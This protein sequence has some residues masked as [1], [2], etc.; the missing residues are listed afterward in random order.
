MPSTPDFLQGHLLKQEDVIG[1]GNAVLSEIKARLD[2]IGA[3]MQERTLAL[4]GG[5]QIAGIQVSIRRLRQELGG[6]D[7]RIGVLQQQL[8]SKQHLIV[9]PN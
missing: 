3:G 2:D 7:L 9:R 6:M 5:T 4:D 1:T 8:L